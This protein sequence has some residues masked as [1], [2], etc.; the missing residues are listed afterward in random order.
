MDA[1]ISLWEIAKFAI[2]N[3]HDIHITTDVTLDKLPMKKRGEY[4]LAWARAGRLPVVTRRGEW[5]KIDP[6]WPIA[7]EAVE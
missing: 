3:A 1:T 5:I 6:A 4:V 2:E 7:E